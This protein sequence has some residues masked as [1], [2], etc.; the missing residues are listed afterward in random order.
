MFN[1]FGR[2]H[3]CCG[4]VVGIGKN[5]DYSHMA[6]TFLLLKKENLQYEW[7][8]SFS[9]FSDFAFEF[10]VLH[11]FLFSQLSSICLGCSRDMDQGALRQGW[12][13][14]KQCPYSTDLYFPSRKHKGKWRK[15]RKRKLYASSALAGHGMKKLS[16]PTEAHSVD[17]QKDVK[18][19]VQADSVFC[20]DSDS[21]AIASSGAYL[22]DF[23][24]FLLP[25]SRGK[26][27]CLIDALLPILQRTD[28]NFSI[29]CA[30]VCRTLKHCFQIISGQ[31][32]GDVMDVGF[33]QEIFDVETSK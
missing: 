12:C 6:Y 21:S 32:D 11:V 25:S 13:L 23:V 20:H 2:R 29:F 14:Q 7:L 24:K 3:K 33:L 1:A 26:R 5:A 15:V 18:H 28:F 22:S 16:S 4:L 8:R 27:R 19:D 31:R 30:Q 10:V 17:L 9:L